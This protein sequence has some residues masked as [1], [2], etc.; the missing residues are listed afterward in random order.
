MLVSG[1][2]CRA[3]NTNTRGRSMETTR[4]AWMMALVARLRPDFQRIGAALPDR[5]CVSC[6]FPTG[7]HRARRTTTGEC[8]SASLERGAHTEIF[9]SPQVTD[10]LEVAETLLHE[11]VH[12]AVGLGAGHG[13]EFRIVATRVGLKGP[14]RDTRL[15]PELRA[16][17]GRIVKELGAFPNHCPGELKTPGQKQPTRMR[18]IVCPKC[19]Y[20]VRT[21]AKWIAAGLPTC[22]CGTRMKEEKKNE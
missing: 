14:M 3:K 11:L 10:P 9:I 1:A 20:T 8:W 21:T 5:L 18:K 15:G 16:K 22:P 17:L 12:A 6:A 13:P 19:G 4:E 7:R 2:A